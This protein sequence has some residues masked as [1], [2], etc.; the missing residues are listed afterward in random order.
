MEKGV[1]AGRLT[2]ELGKLIGGGGGGAPYFG[3]GGG[4][5]PDKF[6]E[7][8]ARILEAVRLQLE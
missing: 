3:Q 5:D 8:K 4:G 1:H 2:T 7:A 6:I